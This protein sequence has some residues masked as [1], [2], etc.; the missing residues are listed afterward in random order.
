[1]RVACSPAVPVAELQPGQEVML[2]EAFNVVAALDYERVGE[3]VLIKE[4]MDDDRAL[5]VAHADE[6]RVV[7]LAGPLREQK[8]RVGDALTMDSRAGFCF[9]KVP[10]AEVEDLVL[11]EVPDIEYSD[12]G[13][14]ASQ[15]E[16]IRDAVGTTLPAP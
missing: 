9:E 10:K 7:H 12:I 2:N 16:Q 4:L 14:L 11:E 3:I 8:L 5:V 15:I 6:E 1:M 13:G